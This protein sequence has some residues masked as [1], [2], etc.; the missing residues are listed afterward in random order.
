MGAI[1]LGN[2][3]LVNRLKNDDETKLQ[4]SLI[5]RSTTLAV[6]IYSRLLVINIGSLQKK[7]KLDFGAHTTKVLFPTND[8]PFNF[9]V[10]H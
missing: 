4:V 6:D 10:S 2:L 7:S 3:H 9:A 5:L 8:L 1:S